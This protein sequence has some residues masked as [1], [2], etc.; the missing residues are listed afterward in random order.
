MVLGALSLLSVLILKPSIDPTSDS[1]SYLESIRVLE[2]NDATE[3]F[4]PNRILTSFGGLEVVSLVGKVF[5]DVVLGWF[6]VNTLLY[7]LASI[8]FFRLLGGLFESKAAALLATMFLAGNYAVLSFGL[9]FYMDMG[10]WA[11][12]IFSIYFLFLYSKSKD[13]K[14]L[15]LSA[16]MVGL[17]GLWKEYAFL[18]SI[19]ILC[20]L[21]Y[22]NWPNLWKA[23]K[24]GFLPAVI[25]IL[26]SLL[27]HFF[28]YQRFGYTYLDW[29]SQNKEIYVYVSRVLEYVKSLGSLLN[30][31]FIP[32][33]IGI[34]AIFKNG[35]V[36]LPN[37]DN[38]AVVAGI[39]LSALP[40]LF[41]PAITQR[42]LFIVVPSAL[43]ISAFAFKKFEGYWRWFLLIFL[44]YAIM[45]FTMDSYILNFVNLPF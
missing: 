9:G 16:A 8:A 37:G 35:R 43:T 7:F 2:G 28:I 12:Y 21:V 14:K 23:V 27:L 40:V 1:P 5:D 39:F 44:A 10:G 6:I 38:K 36:I 11:F 45:S 33:I 41:W 32:I 42:I 19:P 3:K 25:V 17:G 15:L 4:I 18:A 24:R 31:L 29:L 13:Y 26:P 22:E 34:W 20:F 30:F